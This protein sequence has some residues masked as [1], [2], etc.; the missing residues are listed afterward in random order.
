MHSVLEGGRQAAS[1]AVRILA[2]EKPS[3]IKTPP[4]GFASPK[5][6]W[7]EM[8]RWNISE[9]ILPAGSEV[10]FRNLTAWEQYREQILAIC[11]VLLMQA[12]LICW[13]VYEHQRRSRAEV[14]ARH[15]MAELTHMNCIATAG[16]L[17]ASIAHEVSQPL[18]GISTRAS[19]ALRWL[20]AEKPDL[21]RVGASLEHIVAASHRASDIV[22]S[23]RS[24]FKANEI[25]RSPV[26][27]NSLILAVLAILRMDLQR[28]D[29]DVQT[30][31]DAEL[32]PASGD[33]VQLQQV[34]LNL[35]MNGIEAMQAVQPRVLNVSTNRSNGNTVHVS[36]GD[37]GTGLD[38]SHLERI[39]EPLFTTKSN[40][41]GMGLS[42]CRSIIESHDGRIWVTPGTANGSIFQFELPAVQGRSSTP[43]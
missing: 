7:K 28:N 10:Y 21:Q 33:K 14:I 26:D 35:F 29:I 22:T 42:I 2:G 11:V 24:M 5:F 6:N 8:K 34:I 27:V 16:E 38:Q 19:A 12:A 17:S 41:M 18:T 32:P 25:A 9:S 1:V 13:L 36:I 39:F 30:E 4:I 31:L 43:S 3:D 37:L 23:V 40:G 20:R 15:S